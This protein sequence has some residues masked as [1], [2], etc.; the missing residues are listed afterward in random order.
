VDAVRRALERRVNYTD[1]FVL[2]DDVLLIP[3]AELGDDLRRRITFDEG[4]FTLSRRH[5]RS[6]AQVID[7][8]TAALLALFRQPRTIVEAV[9]ENSRALGRDPEARFDELLPHIGTFVENRVLVPAG[10]EAEQELRPQFESGAVVAGC[11]IV[12]CA[13]FVDDRDVYEVRDARGGR[14]ALKLARDASAQSLAM[15]ENEAEMLRRLDGSGVTPTLFDAG[16]FDGRPYVTIEWISGVDAAVAAAQRRH[17]RAALLALCASIA[18][19]Y[20]ALHARGV[21]HA[22][23]HP[24]NILVDGDRVTLLD[25]GFARA[26]DAPP[27]MARAAMPHFFEPEYV[28]AEREGFMVPASAAGE[29]YAVA[30]LLYLLISGEPYCDFRFEHEEMMR[31]IEREPPLPFAARGLAPWPE[32]EPVLC[33]A[34][35]KDPS[36]RHASMAELATLLDAARNPVASIPIDD[37]QLQAWM[38]GGAFYEAR[39]LGASP[40]IALGVLRIAEARGDAALLALA[41]VWHSRATPGADAHAVA[42]LI[43]AARGEREWQL[44]ATEAFVD[45]APRT[46]DAL[47]TAALLLEVSADVVEAAAALRAFGAAALRDAPLEREYDTCLRTARA[48]AYA[49]LRWCAVSGDSLPRRFDL[50]ADGG[51]ADVFTCTLAHRLFGDAEWL[52]RAEEAA[53]RAWEAPRDEGSLCCGT[54]GRAYAL[55]AF[56]KQTG[57]RTWLA[58]ARERAAHAA[59]NITHRGDPLWDGVLGVA[60]L[61][62]D[63][64]A[65]EQSR[66][67][68]FE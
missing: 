44:A 67:P 17:D 3:C 58:R 31:Q 26:I 53:W 5:G 7:R 60:V 39:E 29:Q 42:A 34:L 63:L 49:A 37:T 13:S 32:V 4:D 50:D 35:E 55:L 11:T 57:D 10:S 54:A 21:L 24:F 65:P 64:A 68:L 28:A 14:A 22:D 43:A 2:P 62:A 36:R 9:V 27:R 52:R 23:V 8:D 15:F 51:A 20:A 1:P 6:A 16:L 56:Y 40:T 12:R 46:L 30:A 59:R 66:M 61:V 25:F 41:A 47:L 38:T 33:R 45:S 18:A 48:S 19:A